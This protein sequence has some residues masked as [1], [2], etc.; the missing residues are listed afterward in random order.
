MHAA[1]IPSRTQA[2][3]APRSLIHM[4]RGKERSGG[5]QVSPYFFSC[6][7]LFFTLLC[8][9]LTRVASCRKRMANERICLGEF[10]DWNL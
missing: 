2:A 8:Y 1:I 5:K 6:S 9:W 7:F 4:C 10:A 3:D